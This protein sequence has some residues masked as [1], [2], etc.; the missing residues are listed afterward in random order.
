MTR[1]RNLQTLGR[2]LAVGVVVAASLRLAWMSDDA[3]ITLRTALNITHGW[4]PGYNATEAVQAYTHPLWFVLWVAL[5]SV[6]GQWV[7]G[8]LLVSVAFTGLA[9]GLLVWRTSTIARLILVTALLVLSN[10]FIEYA[11]SGLEN[12]LAYAL[13]GVL[14]ALTLGPGPSSGPGLRRPGWALAFG[15]TAAAVVLTRFDLALLIAPAVVL[16]AWRHRRD[17]R[18]LGIGAAAAILPLVSWAIWSWI[19]YA[20]VLP[21]T[22]E[23]KRNVDIPQVEL[24]VQGLRYLWV[25]F[26]HDPVTPAAIALGIGAALAMGRATER[27]WAAGVLIYLAY[28]VWIGGDFMAGRFLAVP[29]YVAVFLLGVVRV[30]VSRPADDPEAADPEAADPLQPVGVAATA[31]VALLLV[32][33]SAAAGSTPVAL[34]NT[35]APRWEVDTNLNAG[36]SDERGTYASLGRTLKSTL[37]TLALAYTNPD[38]VAYGDGTGL[39]RTLKEINK[40]AQNWPTDDGAF[41]LP[42]EVPQLC[43]FLGTVGIATG[44]ITHLVDT[45][46]LTDRYLAGRPAVARDFAWKPGHFYREVPEGYIEAIMANDPLRVTD[47][48]DAFY[49]KQL[50]ERIRPPQQPTGPDGG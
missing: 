10:A 50:W 46:A 36:V 28:I 1:F 19:T 23:A 22:Y 35:Q 27:T 38:I 12:P 47:P 16:M 15:L 2:V 49:L 18:L 33:G 32:A 48:A 42:S 39:N 30:P 25:S 26:E 14:M 24:V 37:D 8:I 45:C 43:G 11:T 29:V 20:A 5:G 17:L 34:S 6:T 9:V 41:T 44:P 40:A 3:L 13:V 21:N 4:G 7:I 31:A